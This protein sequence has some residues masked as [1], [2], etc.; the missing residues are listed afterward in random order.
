MTG[1]NSRWTLDQNL[2][3]T[4]KNKAIKLQF[5]HIRIIWERILNMGDCNK[6]AINTPWLSSGSKSTTN[7]ALSFNFTRRY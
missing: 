2:A 5:Y 7:L 3:W 6:I 1:K 4:M